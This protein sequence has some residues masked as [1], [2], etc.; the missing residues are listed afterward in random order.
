MVSSECDG[1]AARRTLHLL[2]VAVALATLASGGIL[3]SRTLELNGGVWPGLLTDMKVALVVT[4]FGHVWLWRL[5]GL[6]LLWLAWSWRLRRPSAAWTDWL[7]VIAVA[8]IALTRSQTGHP[9]DHGDFALSVWVDWCHLLAAG[10]WVGSL[11]GMSLAVFPS[12]LRAGESALA[13]AA[14]LFQRLSTLSGIALTVL[15]VCGIYNVVQQ[16]GNIHALWTTRYGLILSTKLIIVLAMILLGAH[17]RYVKLPR[18]LHASGQVGPESWI[19]AVFHRVVG[20]G[21]SMSPGAAV[22]H[23]CARAVLIESLLGL[24][25]IATTAF[26]LHAMPPADAPHHTMGGRMSFYVEP[27]SA[28]LGVLAVFV[29][30]RGPKAG[31]Q[32]V[33]CG[34]AMGLTK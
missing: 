10:A 34:H 23:Q 8:G 31:G 5:P 6:A 11:F 21:A 32:A 13:R 24:A 27:A 25:V 12:L 3:L 4:H 30:R 19:G 18:L 14:V 33:A 2:G 1:E 22:V 20:R 15:L 17:N 28:Q 29:I 9:A 16:L 7:M 26:L